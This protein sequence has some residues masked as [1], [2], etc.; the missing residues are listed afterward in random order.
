MNFN[1]ISSRN[2][3]VIRA[4]MIIL[5]AV[6]IESYAYADGMIVAKGDQF[7]LT[8]DQMH[9]YGKFF[10]E[11]NMKLTS[12]QLFELALRYEMLSREYR[13]GH[14]RGASQENT[15]ESGKDIAENIRE[16]NLYIVDVMKNWKVP[17]SVIQAY[18]RSYPEKFSEGQSEGGLIKVKPLD[19]KIKDEIQFM[20]AQ[21][22]KQDI[23]RQTVDALIGKYHVQILMKKNN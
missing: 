10:S 13:I 1:K 11:S 7:V 15:G 19:D 18:Y 20:I 22:K 5:V 12:E 9:A 16:G 8:E 3:N 14:K 17:D 4:A 21:S 23:V 6:L 2:S